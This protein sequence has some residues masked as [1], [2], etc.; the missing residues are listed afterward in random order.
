MPDRWQIPVFRSGTWCKN[1]VA[2]VGYALI[3]M[4]ILGEFGSGNVA[5]QTFGLDVLAIVLLATNG[6]GLRSRIRALRGRLS[7]PRSGLRRVSRSSKLA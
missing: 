2:A 7:E 1:V 4:Y 6:W 3:A 5:A